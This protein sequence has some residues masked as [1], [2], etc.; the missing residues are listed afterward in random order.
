KSVLSIAFSGDGRYLASGGADGSVR[1]WDVD[2]GVEAAMVQG[3][4]MVW[5]VRFNPNGL[6]LAAGTQDG[7]IH[8]YEISRITE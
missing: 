1:L 3:E 2:R 7:E 4:S 8:Y 6:L 5:C